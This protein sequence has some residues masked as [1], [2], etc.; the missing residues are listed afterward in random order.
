M[1]HTSSRA[2]SRHTG[3]VLAFLTLA[4]AYAC[5]DNGVA[6]RDGSDIRA[7]GTWVSSLWKPG[8]TGLQ[9]LGSASGV[10]EVT[11]N[12]RNFTAH[13]SDLREI[14]LGPM[15]IESLRSA[16]KRR[17]LN[18]GDAHLG[19]DRSPMGPAP[20][21]STLRSF[22]AR[23]VSL[24]GAGGENLRL[25]FVDHPLGGGRPPLAVEILKDGRPVGMN[26]YSYES[27]G[28][29]WRAVRSRSS[30]FDANGK[31][32]LIADHDLSGVRQ[33]P[34]MA[35]VGSARWFRDEIGGGAALLAQLVQPDALHAQSIYD[36]GDYPVYG[37]GSGDCVREA[38]NLAAAT[39]TETAAVAALTAAY[40][41]CVPS[42]ETCI[43]AVLAAQA[44]LAAADIYL[45]MAIADYYNCKHPPS[46]TYG[47][48]GGG[49]GGGGDIGGG[50]GG[51]GGG[52]CG[53]EVWEISY[54]GG[55]SWDYW[56]TF[57]TCQNQA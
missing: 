15:E 49:G 52:S 11:A 37:D 31:V 53:Y 36:Y 50:G 30:L 35:A 13:Q 18:S 57:W 28:N 55:S 20:Q 19:V 40:A 46:S 8:A 25:L 16:L 33:G 4:V 17:P 22:K 29:G 6:P 3:F 24:K 14:P 7:S 56:G 1:R 2:R 48:G 12:A 27:G 26:E 32:T 34:V 51:G 44:A 10:A 45:G 9:Y 42:P 41:S 38:L 54:D 47:Y 43:P 5:S 21:G 39:L 23:S